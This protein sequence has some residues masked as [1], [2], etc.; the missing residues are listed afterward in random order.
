MSSEAAGL[1]I[2]LGFLGWFVSLILIVISF[3]RKKRK[4]RRYALLAIVFIVILII[5]VSL[6]PASSEPQE[7]NQVT[8]VNGS[9]PEETT[10]Q[11]KVTP[12]KALINIEGPFVDF[13]KS[14]YNLTPRE[15]DETYDYFIKNHKFTWDGIVVNSSDDSFTVYSGPEDIYNGEYWAQIKTKNTNLIP[16]TIIISFKD[17]LQNGILPG[18]TVTVSGKVESYGEINQPSSWKLN[19]GTLDSYTPAYNPEL[20]L[21]TFK[22]VKNGMTR[23]EVIKIVGSMT[24]LSSAGEEGTEFYTETYMI[25]GKGILGANANFTFQGGKLTV[26]AQFGLK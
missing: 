17:T 12:R 1:I 7:A 15:Q 21:R 4:T 14:F 20:T 9:S 18:D 22:Q 3:F 5:G 2:L 8:N 19:E 13:S 11:T 16:Y 10:V 6:S 26:K 24:L 23:D 25:E